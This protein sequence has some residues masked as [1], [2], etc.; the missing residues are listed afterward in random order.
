MTDDIAIEECVVDGSPLLE[1]FDADERGGVHVL[2]L[3]G[4]RAHIPEREC[5]VRPVSDRSGRF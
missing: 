1:A 3:S 4:R 5:W 2:G